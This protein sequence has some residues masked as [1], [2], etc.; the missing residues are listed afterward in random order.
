METVIFCCLQ[1]TVLHYSP[2]FLLWNWNRYCI[3][4]NNWEVFVNDDGTRSFLSMEVRAGGLAE[5]SWHF[6]F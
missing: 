1:R 4:F 5:V 2:L 3:D 6:C